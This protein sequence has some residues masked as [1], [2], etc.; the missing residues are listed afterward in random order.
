MK[1]IISSIKSIFFKTCPKTGRIRG[2]NNVF[3]NHKLLFPIFGILALVWFLI[4]VIPKPS[5][6]SYPCQQAAAGIGFSFLAYLAAFFSSYPIFKLIYKYIHR[7]V[8]YLFILALVLGIVITINYAI[9][10]DFSKVVSTF[11]PAEA[12]N[13]PIG[14]AKGLFPGRVVWVRDTASTN[15]DGLEKFWWDDVHTNQKVVSS[16]FSKMLKTYSNTTD[17]KSSWNAIFRHYNKTHKRGD[18]VYK[19]G[20]KV[21]IKINC[22]H[23]KSF[24]WDNEVHPSP[25]AIYA[26]VSQLID[27][28]GVA[29][30]DITLFDGSRFIGNPVYDK[31]RSNP[32]AEYQKVWFASKLQYDAPQ[33]FFPEPDTTSGIYFTIKDTVK[34]TFSKEIK[35]NLAKCFTDATYLINFAILRGHRV[36]GVTMNSKNHF[37][38]IFNPLLKEFKPGNTGSLWQKRIPTD[39][40]LHSFS[41]WDYPISGKLGEPSFAPTMLGHKDLGGKELIYLIDGI[42]T[43]KGNETGMIKYSSIDNDWCSSLFLSQDPVALE[44]VGQDILTNEPNV[45]NGNPS[46]TPALDNYLREAA[47]ANH[48]PSGFKYDPENDGSY[49]TESLGVHEHWN[50]PKDRKY[51]RNLG[52]GKGIELMVVDNNQK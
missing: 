14:V 52:T 41:M 18:N 12:A 1:K 39:F 26:L 33:R 48:P 23:D 5:R 2:I 30:D 45:T 3:K 4:R 21:V 43:S 47:L 50:N 46:F 8:A 17:D 24:T 19:P 16:M 6:I 20:E 36:F 32:G 27:V 38:S 22:N 29:G 35:Y 44:S 25:A 9:A 28:V 34:G 10:P 51:S 11:I 15:W 40:M 49:L 42:F 13:A 31:I 7:N 37:G